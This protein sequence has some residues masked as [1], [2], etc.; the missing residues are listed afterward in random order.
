MRA[1]VMT[2]VG[3]PEVLVD[4]EVDVPRVS[5]REVLLRVVGCGICYRDVLA[6]RGLMRVRP[7]VIPGHEIVGEVVEVGDEVPGTLRK[8]DLVASL[9]YVYDP[10]APGCVEGRE[11]ICRSRVS[12]GEER[13]GC[14]AEYVSLPYWILERVGDP[15]EARPEAYSIAACV[16]GMLVRAFKTIGGVKR[17]E[18]VLVTGAGGGVGIH[19]VQV[20][21]SLG[22]R[23]IAVTRSPEKAE[24]LREFG[25]DHIVVYRDRFSEEVRRLTDGE[26]VDYV[27]E[28][29]GG[30]TLSE[31]IRSLKWGGKILLVGNVDPSP[32]QVSLGLL[33]LRENSIL[34]VYNSC[35]HELREAIELIRRGLVRPVYRTVP[36]DAE[37]IRRAHEVLERG[38]SLGRHVIVP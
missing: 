31:S 15:G 34:G 21:K 12:I 20:A 23:V 27:L 19:A 10:G 6:R 26:G 7:P 25:P 9:I 22:L 36:L 35:K 14:Y 30:P 37:S 38:G 33:I 29:V 2:G 16:V 17:G 8:G 32:Q 3:G 28:A 13:D 18:T 11:N 5:G 24:R 1:V 4:R